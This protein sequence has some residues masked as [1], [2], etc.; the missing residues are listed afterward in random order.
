M[1]IIEDHSISLRKSRRR[2]D[3]VE[4]RWVICCAYPF[5]LAAAIVSRLMPHRDAAG[6]ERPRQSVFREAW[7]AANSSIPFAFMS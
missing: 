1:S 6:F 2:G 4:Y 5:F 7:A 3:E